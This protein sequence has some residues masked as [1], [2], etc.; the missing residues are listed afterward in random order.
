MQPYV[1]EWNSVGRLVFIGRAVL[2]LK[3]KKIKIIWLEVSRGFSYRPEKNPST[4]G[5]IWA[6]EGAVARS[7][8][9]VC[10]PR[11][12]CK[13]QLRDKTTG[14]CL[15]FIHQPIAPPLIPHHF[16]PSATLTSSSLCTKPHPLDEMAINELDRLACRACGETKKKFNRQELS[17][18]DGAVGNKSHTLKGKKKRDF[19][20]CCC[21]W[22]IYVQTSDP[23]KP[24][25]FLKIQFA[26]T[27]GN[28]SSDSCV[29]TGKTFLFLV[30]FFLSWFL[31][32]FREASFFFVFFYKVTCLVC[33]NK[34]FY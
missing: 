24:I 20:C 4:A 1:A 19:C 23:D 3:A 30:L 33:L 26:L 15:T 16:L 11:L 29:F 25:H 9:R 18:W 13:P 17:K 5:W 6:G 8:H 2:L 10:A 7:I 22:H 31:K 32:S 21:C 27:R 28:L 34:T 14:Q 12:T